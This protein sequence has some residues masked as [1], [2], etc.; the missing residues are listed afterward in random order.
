M[1]L[2]PFQNIT[3]FA[4]DG[5]R[6][7]KTDIM[8]TNMITTKYCTVYVFMNTIKNTGIT[9]NA[10]TEKFI[11]MDFLILLLLCFHVLV[12]VKG[13]KRPMHKLH[14]SWLRSR[15]QNCENLYTANGGGLPIFI[16]IRNTLNFDCLKS[17]FFNCFFFRFRR[18]QK[19]LQPCMLTTLV[20]FISC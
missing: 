17:N 5:N 10:Y 20:S 9:S 11:L 7:E 13:R 18:S 15:L 3:Q 8:N 6:G 2:L 1:R 14:N 4:I 12:L 16:K 19:R